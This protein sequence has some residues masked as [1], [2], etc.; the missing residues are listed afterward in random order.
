MV[1]LKQL[2]ITKI[3]PVRLSYGLMENAKVEV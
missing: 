3:L 2:I 1:Y